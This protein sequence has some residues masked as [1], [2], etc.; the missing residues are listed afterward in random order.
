M[1]PSIKTALDG[2]LC[3]FNS[4]HPPLHF[5]VSRDLWAAIQALP[6]REKTDA[7]KQFE[8]ASLLPAI[9]PR[10]HGPMIIEAD[11]LKSI[12]WRAIYKR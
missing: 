1:N 10:F 5:E 3:V 12:A 4:A 9:I 6:I 11:D 7:Q 2:I 8:R